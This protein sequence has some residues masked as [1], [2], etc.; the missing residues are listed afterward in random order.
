M[1]LPWYMPVR[2]MIAVTPFCVPCEIRVGKRDKTIKKNKNII[3]NVI[4]NG[5]KGKNKCKKYVEKKNTTILKLYQLQS[6]KYYC[7]RDK[8][9]V[10]DF[11][12]F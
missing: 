3:N 4:R 12:F 5:E 9:N 11:R 2:I 8:L 7:I 10:N 1:L 6:I